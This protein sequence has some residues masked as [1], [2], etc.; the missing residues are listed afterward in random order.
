SKLDAQIPERSADL[1][2][3]GLENEIG[4]KW[5]LRRKLFAA[6][7]QKEQLRYAR[8]PRA[9]QQS[10]LVDQVYELAAHDRPHRCHVLVRGL[11]EQ[12]IEAIEQ[13]QR[14][15]EGLLGTLIDAGL[16]AG[17]AAGQIGLYRI[18]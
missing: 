16:R 8:N 6:H 4:R 1:V 11:L 7:Q 17:D 3:V 18:G 10:Q 15:V 9:A 5:L 14:L 2:G 12:R 13:R